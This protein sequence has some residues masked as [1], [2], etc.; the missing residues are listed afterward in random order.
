MDFRPLQA[1]EREALLKALRGN[2]A[3]ANA[4]KTAR[5]TS[6]AGGGEVE[7]TD[8]EVIDSIRSVPTHY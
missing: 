4:L 1:A 2:A 7:A 8:D 5:D 3:G 6:F